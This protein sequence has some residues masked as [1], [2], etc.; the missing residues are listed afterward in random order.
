[1][2]A[3][4]FAVDAENP[5]ESA[6]PHPER[7]AERGGTPKNLQIQWLR[8]TAALCVLLYHA[9]YFAGDRLH[10]RAFLKLFGD[11][12]GMF[13]VCL[14]FAVSGYLMA[15]AIRVQA[16]VPF[17]A[18]RIVRIYPL[19][20]LVYAL[21]Y[22]I[23]W[24]AGA[25][26]IPQLRSFLL[27][28][29]GQTGGPL[30]VEWSLMFEVTF[31]V[32]LFFAGLLR[33]SGWLPWIAGLWLVILARQT[34]LHPDGETARIYLGWILRHPAAMP[35]AAGML[36]PSLIERKPPALPLAAA[37]F[38]L[39]LVGLLRVHTIDGMRWLL[40]SGSALILAGA[41]AQSARRPEFGDTRLGRGCAKA[42]DYSYA[43]YLVHVPVILA[44]YTLSGL[45]PP[46]VLWP[47][48]VVASLLVAA[49]AGQAEVSL[50]RR[51]KH[52]ITNTNI[53]AVRAFVLLYLCIF[54]S[55]SVSASLLPL[56]AAVRARQTNA[57][58]ALIRDASPPATDSVSALEKA[59]FVRSQTLL[60]NVEQERWD[61]PTLTLSGWSVD[62]DR[63]HPSPFA[64]VAYQG[65]R[66][67]TAVVT[68]ES[69]P[70]VRRAYHS[71][72]YG[73]FA[74]TGKAACLP[75]IHVDV[76]AV[77][78]DKRYALLPGPRSPP[79]CR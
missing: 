75:G 10:D 13:G 5:V 36:I 49:L 57:A 51:S 37:G 21:C 64:V 76:F 24:P 7:R 73:G 50:Y 6:V 47:L 17:L 16:P 65:G 22:A 41:V 38:F 32:S 53:W 42:A 15:T 78:A 55:V 48:G 56:D 18:H 8:A 74:F 23:S 9:S 66:F 40:G 29:V 69:R 39:C 60:G 33:L 14:F 79:A 12:A 67:L 77:T 68:G 25:V 59:G 31:Y 58:V 70:D 27:T 62:Y 20:W 34:C 72:R 19:L 54:L 46:A 43:L 30:G 63:R 3:I 35:L 45:A 28:P 4:P 1:M 2:S 26:D 44:V 52:L 71:A 11:S 61:G